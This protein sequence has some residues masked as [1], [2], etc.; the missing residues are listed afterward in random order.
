LHHWFRALR[1]AKGTSSGTSRSPMMSLLLPLGNLDLESPYIRRWI[2]DRCYWLGNL[3]VKS[4]CIQRQKIDSYRG[5]TS[6]LNRRILWRIYVNRQASWIGKFWRWFDVEKYTMSAQI[7]LDVESTSIRRKKIHLTNRRVNRSLQWKIDQVQTRVSKIDQV[8]ALLWKNDQLLFLHCSWSFF[9]TYSFTWWILETYPFT[10]SFFHGKDRNVDV[11]LTWI[12]R[13]KVFVHLMTIFQ[14]RI[15]VYSTLNF[16][17]R[18][19]CI[20]RCRSHRLPVTL[21][22]R[23]RNLLSSNFTFFLLSPTSVSCL[24]NHSVLSYTS[25][26]I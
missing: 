21:K 8:K 22:K 11:A 19:T 9:E 16:L 24:W 13:W 10:W 6:T 25:S 15:N 4:T 23:R 7:L 5:E 18:L 12:R 3:N 26:V 1:K 2:I 14:R 17:C 20:P